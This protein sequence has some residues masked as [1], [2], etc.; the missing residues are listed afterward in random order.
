MWKALLLSAYRF[1]TPASG[2]GRRQEKQMTQV[3][4]GNVEIASEKQVKTRGTS[5][6]RLGDFAHS[7]RIPR[8]QFGRRREQQLQ[9]VTDSNAE[10]SDFLAIA[11]FVCRSMNRGHGKR[12]N[13][14]RKSKVS[15]DE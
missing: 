1:H 9:L 8:R 13:C 7:V 11:G 10:I 4:K 2:G 12:L 14:L 15:R 3:H 6:S 5:I